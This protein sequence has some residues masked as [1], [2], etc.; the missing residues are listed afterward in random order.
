MLCVCVRLR[1]ATQ[2]M[3]ARNSSAHSALPVSHSV[4]GCVSD[5]TATR[6]LVYE[7]DGVGDDEAVISDSA[8]HLM[9]LFLSW[10]MCVLI[11]S[12]LTSYGCNSGA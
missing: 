9:A 4:P 6:R 8:P 10:L 5:V 3:H 1:G 11:S 12:P 7:T 2:G